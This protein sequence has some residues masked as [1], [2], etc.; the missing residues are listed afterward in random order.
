MTQVLLVDDEKNIL[1]TLSIGLRRHAFDVKQAQSGF[2]AIRIMEEEP[3]DIVV[4]DVRMRPMDG[5]A[6]AYRLRKKFPWVSIVLMSAYGFGDEFCEQEDGLLYPQLTKPFT[7]AEL[8]A[9]IREER[10]RIEHQNQ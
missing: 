2:E 1:A 6:L 7:V 9:V 8:V 3:C 4:S 10:E 5:Y